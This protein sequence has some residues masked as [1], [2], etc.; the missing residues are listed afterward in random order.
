MTGV[1]EINGA[2]FGIKNQI[3]GSVFPTAIFYKYE[4]KK[5]GPINRRLKGQ[6]QMDILYI[7]DSKVGG[8]IN[9]IFWQSEII[10]LRQ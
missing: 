3:I 1:G 7:M 9:S 10:V 4:R 2:G 6:I 5:I 8:S